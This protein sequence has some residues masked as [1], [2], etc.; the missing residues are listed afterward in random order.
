MTVN[1]GDRSWET[2]EHSQEGNSTEVERERRNSI[3]APDTLE[4][5]S[6]QQEAALDVV[7]EVLRLRNHVQQI[8]EREAEGVQGNLL[9]PPPAY[10]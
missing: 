3:G 4:S 6:V 5:Q 2:V 9:D 10:V 7:A 8:I 1:L